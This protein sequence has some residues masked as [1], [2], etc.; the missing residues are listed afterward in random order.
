MDEIKNKIAE[1]IEISAICNQKYWIAPEL[2][3]SF[4]FKVDSNGVVAQCGTDVDLKQWMESNSFTLE[5][6]YLVH[7]DVLGFQ[8][9]M[10]NPLLRLQAHSKLSGGLKI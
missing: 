2:P 5:D 9:N 6:M 8:K 4:F 10:K 7:N 1:M 3:F